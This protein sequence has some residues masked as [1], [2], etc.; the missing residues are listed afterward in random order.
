MRFCRISSFDGLRGAIDS[1]WVPSL[2]HWLNDSRNQHFTDSLIQWICDEGLVFLSLQFNTSG[3][4]WFSDSMNLWV[5]DSTLHDARQLNESWT[6]WILISGIQYFMESV[7]HWVSY[8]PKKDNWND[9]TDGDWC[10]VL[11]PKAALSWSRMNSR[12]TRRERESDR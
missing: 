5:S 2:N 11:S 8:Q 7:T 10:Y 6:L 3:T 4:H 9:L 12:R 1:L